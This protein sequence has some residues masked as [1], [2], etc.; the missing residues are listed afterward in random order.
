MKKI[1]LLFLVAMMACYVMHGQVVVQMEDDGGVYKIPCTINGLKLKFIFDTGASS[2]SLSSSIANMMLENDYLSKN[3]IKGSGKSQIADGQIVDHTQIVIRELEV[4][5]LV[6]H[7]VEA[8]VIHQQSAPLLL[9]QSA[10]R[11][12]GNVSIDGNKLIINNTSARGL[13]KG[14]S[15]DLPAEDVERI[16]QEA[17]DFFDAGIKTLAVEKFDLLYQLDRLSLFDYELYAHCL[18]SREVKRYSDAVRVMKE[19]EGMKKLFES[20]ELGSFY[21]ELCRYANL[22]E[23]YQECINYGALARSNSVFPLFD[24][25]DTVYWCASAYKSLGDLSM[26]QRITNDFLSKYFDFMGIS[27]TDCW[28]KGYRDETVADTYYELYLFAHNAE[29]GKKYLIIA[30]SWGQKDAIELCNKYSFNYQVKP[31]EFVY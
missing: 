22:A 25:Y 13:V 3:D 7:N 26:A 28:E 30:A 15:V 19:F 24:Y 31:Y 10:I 21:S 6:L 29:Q 11:K 8:V 17:M 18:A 4:G 16:R 27:S 14:Q 2:V 1:L 9:G 23:E 12:L 20:D 5:G